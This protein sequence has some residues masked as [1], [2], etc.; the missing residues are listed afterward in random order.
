MADGKAITA[1][2]HHWDRQKRYAQIAKY[3]AIAARHPGDRV[4]NRG[5]IALIALLR[6]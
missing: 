6:S 5:G 1:H 2:N 3:A 4:S